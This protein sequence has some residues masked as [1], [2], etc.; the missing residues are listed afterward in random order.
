MEI[1]DIVR[2]AGVMALTAFKKTNGKNYSLKGPHDYLT[3]TDEIIESYVRTEIE[4]R[5]PGDNV[6]GEE[7]GGSAGSGRLWIVDPIDGTANFARCIPHF[8]VSLAFFEE[9]RV[10]AGAIYAPATDEMFTAE[11]GKGARLNGDIMRVSN[12]HQ[13]SAAS[14]EVGWSKNTV[15]SEYIAL[16]QRSLDFG[17][18]VR[19]GG[20][21]ALGLAYVAAG[22]SEA[23][24]EL[25]INAWDVAAGIL[26]VQEAGGYVNDFWHDND[27]T[28][29]NCVLA[30]NA[31]LGEEMAE[32]TG[33]TLIS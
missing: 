29:S 20:S 31:A 26:I 32:L 3:A 2:C 15:N 9:N 7:A 23:Y 16:V 28:N 17:C 25:Y 5:F 6:L 33:I 21:G 14:I 4:R 19:R 13:L 30:T 11:F 22:R 27:F 10:I 12:Q 1:E 18:S 24:V 8:C